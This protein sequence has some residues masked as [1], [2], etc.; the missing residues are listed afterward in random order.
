MIGIFGG[1]FDPVHYGHLQPVQD[2]YESLGLEKVLFIP[3]NIPPHRAQ[4]VLGA[5]QRVELLQL[6][7]VG[8][9][10]FE[11]DLRELTRSG[12]SYMV[13]TLISLQQDYP[14][15]TLLLIIGMDALA[16][17][18]GWSRWQQLFDLCHIVVT[19]RPG[20]ELPSGLDEEITS[21]LTEDAG[22][23]AMSPAGRILLKSAS[24]LDISSSEIRRRTEAGDTASDLMPEAVYQKYREIMGLYA[25]S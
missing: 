14:G 19:T 7:L 16:G 11:L 15:Q 25:Q 13:D 12:P 4:P 3:N 23:L 20:H 10:G 22:H 17:L 24:L 6:A 5:A 2:V 9:E 1:T 21:R 8:R 18:T